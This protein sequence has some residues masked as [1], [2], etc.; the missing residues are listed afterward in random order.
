MNEYKIN[1]Y[2]NQRIVW[3]PIWDIHEQ[4]QTTYQAAA[5]SLLGSFTFC[6]N[7]FIMD[8]NP[9]QIF[10]TLFTG[11]VILFIYC[12]N[13]GRLLSSEHNWRRIRIV[14][15]GSCLQLIIPTIPALAWWT[16]NLMKESRSSCRGLKPGSAQCGW[17]V[18]CTRP[19]CY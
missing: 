4:E 14:K 10:K 6:E 19:W 5:V 3:L 15:G 17:A 7:A 11:T 18:V 8:I 9:F 13:Y 12:W 16:R 2:T 1:K